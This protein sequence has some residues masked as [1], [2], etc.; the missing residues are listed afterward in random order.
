MLLQANSSTSVAP[1]TPPFLSTN[2]TASFEVQVN[3]FHFQIVVAL[4]L[5]RNKIKL[6]SEVYGGR[7][8]HTSFFLF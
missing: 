5:S 8:F 4:N 3:W 7:F 2:V 6:F 1:N